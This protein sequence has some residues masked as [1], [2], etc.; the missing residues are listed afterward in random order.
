MLLTAAAGLIA[1]LPDMKVLF[2]LGRQ[3]SDSLLKKKR[4]KKQAIGAVSSSLS[5][6]TR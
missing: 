4:K 6:V 5:E 3:M 2:L 1:S